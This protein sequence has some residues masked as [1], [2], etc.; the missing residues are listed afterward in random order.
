MSTPIGVKISNKKPARGGALLKTR[1]IKKLGGN[2]LDQ[3]FGSFFG[4]RHRMQQ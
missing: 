2:P 1:N 4:G 3:K